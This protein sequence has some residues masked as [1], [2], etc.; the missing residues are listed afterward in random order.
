MLQ[1][2]PMI[3]HGVT[4]L[5]PLPRKGLIGVAI[6][7][8]LSISGCGWDSPVGSAVDLAAKARSVQRWCPQPLISSLRAL[9]ALFTP[10]PSFAGCVG[11]LS[12]RGVTSPSQ[13]S[14]RVGAQH[15]NLSADG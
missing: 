15:G 5:I 10:T 14:R 6:F 12:R 4:L 11:D 3:L 2:E 9:G 1:F 8:C 13:W 7:A